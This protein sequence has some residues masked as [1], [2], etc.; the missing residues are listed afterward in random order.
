MCVSGVEATALRS[1]RGL[2]LCVCLLYSVGTV[3]LE[4][5]LPGTWSLYFYS[6]CSHN[7]GVA[8]ISW[9]YGTAVRAKYG[10]SPDIQSS[11]LPFWWYKS[12]HPEHALCCLGVKRCTFT[13]PWAWH[14]MTDTKLFWSVGSYLKRK[15]YSHATFSFTPYIGLLLKYVILY[16]DGSYYNNVT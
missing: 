9:W 6:C 7:T 4:P 10:W 5:S 8:R 1:E 3:T 2:A 16:H 15:M 12:R 14:G 11:A 13:C